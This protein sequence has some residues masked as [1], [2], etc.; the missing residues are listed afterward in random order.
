MRFHAHARH[1]TTN[2]FKPE[3]DLHG[4]F[5]TLDTSDFKSITMWAT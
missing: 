4:A 2:K 3:Y 1:L 5:N